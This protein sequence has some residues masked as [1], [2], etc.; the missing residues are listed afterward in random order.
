[1][2]GIL[3]I[4]FLLH[5]ACWQDLHGNRH[6]SGCQADRCKWMKGVHCKAW[7]RNDENNKAPVSPKWTF[8]I[9]YKTTCSSGSEERGAVEGPCFGPYPGAR[10]ALPGAT[11]RW[12]GYLQRSTKQ[13]R[14]LTKKPS[15]FA[16]LPGAFARFPGKSLD[17]S[18]E[19]MRLTC[20]FL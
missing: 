2:G 17:L 9:T 13:T 10:L 11:A 18:G 12:G 20:I 15:S 14:L 19:D 6:P 4:F 1:M 7:D 16:S 3:H 5:K 8:I